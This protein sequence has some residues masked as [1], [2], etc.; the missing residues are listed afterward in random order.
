MRPR[1]PHGVSGAFRAELRGKHADVVKASL[2][3]LRARFAS[4]DR[5]EGHR[6]D[7]RS[8]SPN[9]LGDSEEPSLREARALQQRK[10]SELIERLLSLPDQARAA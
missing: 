9:S 5:T 2:A 7:G 4:D 1:G 6:K 3:I 10:G 8:P